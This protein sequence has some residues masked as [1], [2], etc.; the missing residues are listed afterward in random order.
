MEVF[1]PVDDIR[2]RGVTDVGGIEGAGEGLE[3]R[4]VDDGVMTEVWGKI[5]AI[6]D[7]GVGGDDAVR[8]IELGPQLAV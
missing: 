4:D 1:F 3:S 8:T 2:Q 6:S 7:V 5:E